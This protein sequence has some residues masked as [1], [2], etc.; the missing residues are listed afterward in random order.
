MHAIHKSEILKT[1]QIFVD[2][3]KIPDRQE[4]LNAVKK[5]QQT[6]IFNVV[7]DD[8]M[9]NVQA[10]P[11]NQLFSQR[12]KT[13]AETYNKAVKTSIQ[14]SKDIFK[15]STELALLQVN[16]AG[17]YQIMHKANKKIKVLNQ[18]KLFKKLSALMTGHALA[19]KNTGELIKV[20]SGGAMQYYRNEMD[21]LVELYHFRNK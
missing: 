7:Q 9:M 3:I 21:P 8:G 17:Q 18:S 10:I 5:C 2:F 12:A 16:L 6:K 15:K 11:E 13:F 20:Y 19:Q 14:L 1:C 4:W